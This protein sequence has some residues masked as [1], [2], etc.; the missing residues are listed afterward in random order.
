MSE[1]GLIYRSIKKYFG[2]QGNTGYRVPGTSTGYRTLYRPPSSACCSFLVVKS[3]PDENRVAVD[4]FVKQEVENRLA[5]YK[6]ILEQQCRD[7]ILEEAGKLADSILISEARLKRDSLLKPPKPVKPEK[8]EIKQ[9]KDSVNLYPL[10][11]D[12]TTN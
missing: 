7:N 11:R 2:C 4:N 12:T 10:F 5:S 1:K 6:R 8:P 3:G 9:L